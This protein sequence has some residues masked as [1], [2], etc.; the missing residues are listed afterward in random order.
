MV[1]WI[2]VVEFMLHEKIELAL[3]AAAELSGHLK[4]CNMNRGLLLEH[5]M[6]GTQ[7]KLVHHELISQGVVRE[8]ACQK[9]ASSKVPYLVADAKIQ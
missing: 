8:R 2:C 1:T 3:S 5:R 9:R 4:W 7:N 6:M